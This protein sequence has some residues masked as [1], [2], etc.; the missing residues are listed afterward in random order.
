MGLV[1]LETP[2]AKQQQNQTK[3]KKRLHLSDPVSN[4]VAEHLPELDLLGEQQLHRLMTPSGQKSNQKRS[5][6]ARESS[7]PANQK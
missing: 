5:I 2:G 1:V 3:S 6:C 7:I 4:H